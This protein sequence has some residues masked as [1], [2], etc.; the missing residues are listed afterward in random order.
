[1]KKSFFLILSL[2][3]LIGLGFLNPALAWHLEVDNSDGDTTFDFW[4]RTEGETINL[5]SYS[6]GFAFD[7]TELVFNG[8]YTDNL[9]INFH[10]EYPP[11]LMD[12]GLMYGFEAELSGPPPAISEDYLLGTVT[13]D[14]LPGATKDGAYDV[15]FPESLSDPEPLISISWYDEEGNYIYISTMEL[16]LG[17]HGSGLANGSGLDVGASPVPVPAAAW[18]LGS[19]LVGL[20]GIRRKRKN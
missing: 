6:L 4:L 8:V 1:M 18:L 2:C 15:W 20:I 11:E 16:I 7:D 5:Q 14:I 12:P 10:E 3:V 13:M 19:G 17:N 9:P